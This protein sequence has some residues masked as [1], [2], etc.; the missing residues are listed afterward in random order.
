MAQLSGEALQQ[1]T[2]FIEGESRRWVEEFIAG[3]R[4]FLRTRK[5]TASDRLIE[6]F[7]QEITSTLEGQWRTEL[8]LEFEEHGRFIDMRLKPAGGGGDYLAALEDWIVR[9][10]LEEQF[11]RT[12]MARRR[13]KKEPENVLRQMAWG[14][15]VRRTQ[16][17][18]R[19]QWYNKSKSAAI[20]DLYNRVAAGL[21]D[22]VVEEIKKGFKQG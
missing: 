4:A 8:L 5:I 10:G 16:R 18:R 2:T 1:L 11:V 13:L 14:I 7:A 20:T 6:S 22:I 19:R 21:P 3:R 15:A 12:F 9:K 17:Y